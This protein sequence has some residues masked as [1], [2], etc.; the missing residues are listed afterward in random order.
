MP[1]LVR[2]EGARD[3]EARAQC[4]RV[5][6]RARYMLR[7][8]HRDNAELSLL[9]CDDAVMRRLNREHRNQDKPTDVLSFALHEGQA[10]A[11]SELALGDVVI[12]LPTARRQAKAHGWPEELEICLL[13]AHGVL[14]LLGYDHRSRAEERRMMARAHLLMAAG[15][16]GLSG[17]WTSSLPPAHSRSPA[18]SRTAG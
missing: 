6:R 15:L 3:S 5:A 8:L 9:L 4:V 1:V 17:G 13:L 16:V 11:G 18:G 12:A 14:H 2:Y 10:V 7:A